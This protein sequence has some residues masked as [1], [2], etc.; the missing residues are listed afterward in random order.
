MTFF[1][2]LFA[3]MLQHI[4]IHDPKPD[5]WT[6]FVHAGRRL[7]AAVVVIVIVGLIVGHTVVM[8]TLKIRPS[9]HF[10]SY[11]IKECCQKKSVVKFFICVSLWFCFSLVLLKSNNSIRSQVSEYMR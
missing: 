1:F 5:I 7:I 3:N 9:S 2:S 6:L 11:R 8:V 4:T 10:W